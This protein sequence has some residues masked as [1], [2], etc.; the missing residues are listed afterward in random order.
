MKPRGRFGSKACISGRIS[1]SLSNKAR[2]REI[3]RWLLLGLGFLLQRWG[4]RRAVFVFRRFY[5]FARFVGRNNPFKSAI[6]C[7]RTKE[8]VC[9]AGE[10]RQGGT[11]KL[12]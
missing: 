9:V 12:T 1:E 8:E 3:E 7:H 4:V 6:L 5:F 10:D 2:L 11:E